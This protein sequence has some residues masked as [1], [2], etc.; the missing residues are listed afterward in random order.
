MKLPNFWMW[1]LR[2]DESGAWG[3]VSQP[4]PR[5]DGAYHRS[6]AGG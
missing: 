3:C 6:K 5:Q 1:R 2:R 4:L